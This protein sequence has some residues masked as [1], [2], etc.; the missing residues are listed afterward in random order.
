MGFQYVSIFFNWN[1]HAHID[2]ETANV[3]LHFLN[4]LL[5]RIS[6][7]VRGSTSFQMMVF[8]MAIIPRKACSCL[9]DLAVSVQLNTGFIWICVASLY[10]CWVLPFQCQSTCFFL[11][12]KD[13]TNHTNHL[14]DNLQFPKSLGIPSFLKWLW[15]NIYWIRYH[16]WGSTYHAASSFSCWPG[17]IWRESDQFSYHISGMSPNKSPYIYIVA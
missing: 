10:I 8:T 1:C 16:V 13:N 12:G 2:I 14:D 3:L 11:K 6:T 17:R 4:F 15:I 9:V 5:S 7:N